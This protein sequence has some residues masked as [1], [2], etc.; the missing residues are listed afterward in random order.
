MQE[1]GKVYLVGAG[2]GDP[3]L[4][5]VKG[6]K[7]LQL[8]DVIVYDRLVNMELLRY[9]K[10]GTELIFCGKSPERHT[11]PQEEINRVLVF[12]AQQG[13]T[14][15]RL[16]GGD[17]SIFGRVGEEAA[18]C[19]K[20][21]IS[22]EIV[23]GIT[24]GVAAPAYAGI[25]LTHRDLSSS[26][27]IVTGHK[28]VDGEGDPV[29]WDQLATSVQTLVI[30]MGVGNLPFIREQL[31]AHGRPSDT[32]VAL[33]RWGTLAKQET[34][35]GTLDNIVE[36]VQKAKFKSPAIIVVGEVVRLREQLA[37]FE[38]KQT[39]G[40]RTEQTE[41]GLPALKTVVV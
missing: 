11:M 12:H 1:A 13:K 7:L 18:Y 24:S 2:P 19:A 4:I 14:V 21:G 17:P 8:A 34:L 5:T 6:A 41:D 32:P 30:Y 16:K 28:R 35:V 22:F 9:A 27:A 15:V 36:Q 25:P 37:W 20:H 40:E 29:R 23:P 33:V 31:L 39:A 26:V 10:P 3:E 38:S